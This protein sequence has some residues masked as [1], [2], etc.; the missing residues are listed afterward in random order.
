M[1]EI[2]RIVTAQIA[3]IETM[4]DDDA[5]I[6]VK[7]QET[8]KSNIMADLKKIYNADDVVVKVQ[9]FLRDIK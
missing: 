6:I 5:D 2:T 8:A 7:A 9:D 3:I 4:P 1:K